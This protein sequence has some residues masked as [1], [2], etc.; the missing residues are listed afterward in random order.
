MLAMNPVSSPP[1]AAPKW[2]MLAPST[3][4]HAAPPRAAARA[5]RRG[6]RGAAAR[7]ASQHR[8]VLGG[9]ADLA[10]EPP[11]TSRLP[12][13]PSCCPRTLGPV[14]GQHRNPAHWPKP[15][16]FDPGRWTPEAVAG[17]P[18]H[19]FQAFSSGPRDCIGRG[20]ARAEGLA[21]LSALF[22][23]FEFSH[24]PPDGGADAAEPRDHHMITRKPAGGMWVRV[25]ARE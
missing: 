3:S 21:V 2:R 20:L 23:R 18:T 12:A 19:A 9:D 10:L 15:E 16:E 25:A 1:Q 5:A 13:R 7:H 8:A 22:R 6:G 4:R 24:A 14:S 17:R 11:D